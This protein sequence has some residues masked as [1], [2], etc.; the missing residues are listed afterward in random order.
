[1]STRWPVIKAPKNIFNPTK[2]SVRFPVVVKD[3]DDKSSVAG[4]F[5]DII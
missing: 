5:V 1:M 3:A 4:V 2:L